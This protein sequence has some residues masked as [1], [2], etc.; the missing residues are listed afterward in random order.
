MKFNEFAKIIG[1]EIGE[2]FDAIFND[3]AIY[4]DYHVEENGV[5]DKDNYVVYDFINDYFMGKVEITKNA[6]AL[7]YI[8]GAIDEL[9]S[10][11]SIL[12]DI[13]NETVRLSTVGLEDIKS[14]LEESVAILKRG[15]K[16]V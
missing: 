10:T 14:Y 11:I 2:R 15:N 16:W 6:K 3:I 9:G 8:E 4:K 13:N 5:Y 1:V 12:K 7:Y